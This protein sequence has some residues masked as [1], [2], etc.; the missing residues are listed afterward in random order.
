MKIG[1]AKV[2]TCPGRP[3]ILL[4]IAA[5]LHSLARSFADCY[6]VGKALPDLSMT[7]TRGAKVG[8]V[9]TT[10][11]RNMVTGSGFSLEVMQYASGTAS[12]NLSGAIRA[13][14]G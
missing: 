3:D 14:I 13:Y 8:F 10:A 1:G 11:S 12:P 5:L 9:V 2:S 7:M 4:H 6:M